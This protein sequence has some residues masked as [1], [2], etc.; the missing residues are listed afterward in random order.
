MKEVDAYQYCSFEDLIE[1]PAFRKWILSPDPQMDAFW[2]EVQ[3]A[4]PENALTIKEARAFLLGTR[5]YFEE[6]AQS[7]QAIPSRLQE[8]LRESASGNPERTD[9]Y[10]NRWISRP[11]AVAA[12]IGLLLSLLSWFWL[13]RNSPQVQIVATHYGEWKTINL[14]DGSEVKLNANSE[15][16]YTTNWEP[17]QDRKVWLIGEAFFEVTKDAQGAKFTVYTNDLAIEVL[18][19]AFNVHSRSDQ[20]KVFLE[21]GKVRLDMGSSE[22]TLEPGDFIAYSSTQKQITDFRKKSGERHT[23][24]KDGD[25]IMIDKNVA[26]ILNKL[27]EIFG[28]KAVVQ[29]KDLLQEQRTVGIP[30]DVIE[31]AIPIM[32]KSLDVEMKIEGKRLIIR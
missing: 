4:Y 19:T 32:E 26:E 23:S 16:K 14:P 5:D 6:T 20:T 8:L 22:K 1:D 17:G 31:V 15:L 27:E 10:S 30:M 9:Q 7:N 13:G 28:Y 18:G 29:N 2:E 11:W 21:E 3:L 12:S 24:W 25:L